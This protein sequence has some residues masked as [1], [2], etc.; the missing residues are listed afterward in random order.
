VSNSQ[1]YLVLQADAIGDHWINASPYNFSTNPYTIIQ[2]GRYYDT[3]VT[4]LSLKGST[5]TMNFGLAS[6]NAGFLQS[7]TV[8]TA[9]TPAGLEWKFIALSYDSGLGKIFVNKNTPINVSGLDPAFS[10]FSYNR[11]STIRSR[12][13]VGPLLFYTRQLTPGEVYYIYDFYYSKFLF[14]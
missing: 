11:N 5:P 14:G 13:E 8:S 2:I 4:T 7:G 10:D 12:L 3:D 9:G 1:G 6:G